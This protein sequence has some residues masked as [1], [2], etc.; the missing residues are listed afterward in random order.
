MTLTVQENAPAGGREPSRCRYPGCPNPARATGAPGRRPGYCGQDVPE[1]RDGSAVLVRH[2]AMTAFRRRSQLTGQPGEPHPV[3]AAITRAGAIRDDALAAMT[4]LAGQLA[5]TIDQLAAL[6]EQLAAAADP[7]AAEAQVEAVRAQAA[8]QLEHARAETAAHA[9]ARHTA[10]LEAAEA[11]A[12][13]AE[14][15]TLMEAQA[16]D[17]TRAGQAAR[18]A[19]QELADA[20][21]TQTSELAAARAQ[22]ED[23]V[24]ARAED[25]ARHDATLSALDAT[26]TTLREQLARTQTALDRE[27]E[28]Q[29]ETVTLLR[30]LI[31]SPQQPKTTTARR[32]PGDS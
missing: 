7:E 20:R 29:H 4:R 32:P 24:R 25:R 15:I 12:A 21:A 8:A 19:R 11:R 2:T 22:T 13:A 31:T 23:A 27:H 17:L 6:G 3:T 9:A 18:T 14:A 30:G 5:T 1:D 16:G 26:V 10:E 28:R